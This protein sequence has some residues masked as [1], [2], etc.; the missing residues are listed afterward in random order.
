MNLFKKSFCVLLVFSIMLFSQ[1]SF[2]YFRDD[3]RLEITHNYKTHIENETVDLVNN[4][5]GEEIV[6]KNYEKTKSD[7]YEVE[8]YNPSSITIDGSTAIYRAEITYKSKDLGQPKPSTPPTN[9]GGDAVIYIKYESKA[10]HNL[11]YNQYSEMR[12]KD[13]E[14]LDLKNYVVDI[15][16]FKHIGFNPSNGLVKFDAKRRNT[17][18]IIY[19][20][21]NVATTNKAQENQNNQ[22]K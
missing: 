4:Y 3:A 21:S 19:E 13:G 8:S 5:P 1:H 15:K 17:G 2:A 14:V 6:L 10:G 11:L 9:T 12:G 22:Q 18:V 20:H 16:L 7:K